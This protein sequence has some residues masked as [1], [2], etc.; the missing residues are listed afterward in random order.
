M[1]KVKIYYDNRQNK[2][3]IQKGLKPLLK[4]VCKAALDEENFE[5]TAEISLSFVDDGQIRELNSLYRDKDLATD[6]LSFP[7][8][9]DGI[10]FDIDEET[11]RKQLGDIV[12]SLE[13]AE[14]QAEA[15]NH[16]FIREVCFLTVHSVL[17][18]LGYD[19][20][21][22]APVPKEK[23]G[24]IMFKKQEIILETLGITRDMTL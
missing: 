23:S 9:E 17:H 13:R 19:H 24:D 22:G 15:Y 3:K 4:K 6:V 18:L 20:E 7:L 5:G 11:G 2:I 10:N 16:T 14:A 21:E 12:I 1:E 8:S